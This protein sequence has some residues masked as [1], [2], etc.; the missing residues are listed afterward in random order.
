MPYTAYAVG[1]FQGGLYNEYL[2]IMYVK[3]NIF[4]KYFF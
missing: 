1:N 3:V 2:E 4:Y